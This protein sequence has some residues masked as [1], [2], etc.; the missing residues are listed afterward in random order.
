MCKGE[1]LFFL[2]KLNLILASSAGSKTV[3][4]TTSAAKKKLLRGQHLL[5]SA[6]LDAKKIPIIFSF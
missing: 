1:E 6:A 4:L 2:H 3:I 5:S